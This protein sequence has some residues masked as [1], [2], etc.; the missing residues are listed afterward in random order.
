MSACSKPGTAQANP[1]AAPAG[2]HKIKSLTMKGSLLYIPDT[3]TNRRKMK[4]V[5]T[6]DN[7]S[8]CEKC[9]EEFATP[10][11]RAE[12]YKWKSD[13]DFHC[14]AGAEQLEQFKQQFEGAYFTKPIWDARMR[15]NERHWSF[16]DRARNTIRLIFWA[17]VAAL[18]LSKLL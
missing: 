10:D 3:P 9:T 5:F 4:A 17:T 13:N 7:A 8:P 15:H 14:Q 2:N 6:K 18:I 1:F 12:I 11:G 16:K